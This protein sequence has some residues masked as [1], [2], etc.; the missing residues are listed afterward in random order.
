MPDNVTDSAVRIILAA[1]S[2]ASWQSFFSGLGQVRGG[3]SRAIGLL[4][5]VTQ[6][7]A[8]FYAGRLLPN[9]FALDLGRLAVWNPG[10]PS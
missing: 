2:A 10:A 9:T 7:H 1:F 8:V 4:L 3:S 5:T 6:F